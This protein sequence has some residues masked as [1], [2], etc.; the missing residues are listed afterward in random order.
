MLAVPRVI[1]NMSSPAERVMQLP[2]ITPEVQV[3]VPN[4]LGIRV[5][6]E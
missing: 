3:F 5:E 4:V 1:T 2:S 6:F